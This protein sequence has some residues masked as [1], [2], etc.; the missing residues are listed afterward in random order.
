MSAPVRRFLGATAVLVV[1]GAVWTGVAIAVLGSVE[2]GPA[3]IQ[4]ND[5][6]GPNPPVAAFMLRESEDPM[7][8]WAERNDLIAHGMGGVDGVPVTNSR[9]A[10]AQNY[11]A[12]YRV[13]EVD[14]EVTRDGHVVA[15][16]NWERS[17]SPGQQSPADGVPTLADFRKMRIRGEYTPLALDDVLGF[18]RRYPDIYIMTDIKPR[19]LDEQMGALDGISEA[20]GSDK[21]LR[22][23]F[24]VQI[25][26]GSE[27]NYVRS[28]GFREVVYTFYRLRTTPEAALDFC[29]R[30]HIRFVTIPK[31]RATAEFVRDIRARGLWC[32][33]H[34]VN[35]ANEARVLRARGVTHLYSDS[36]CP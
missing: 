23:R 35:D 21:A 11:A 16:H 29:E 25:Y 31:K 18:M 17:A 30:E 5:R 32:A 6:P 3:R 28:K 1:L 33:V 12:G 24:V 13:F 2:G 8:R 9:E 10:L 7:Y 19:D 4:A 20:L 26:D 22:E 15:R 36:M 34:T 14:F 27:L